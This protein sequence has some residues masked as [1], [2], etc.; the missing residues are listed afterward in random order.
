MKRDIKEPILFKILKILGPIILVTGIVLLIV[1]MV[2]F[3]DGVASLSGF[4]FVALALL[5]IGSAATMFGLIPQMQKMTIKTNKYIHQA[6]KEDL[7]EIA[8]TKAEIA[9]D[10]LSETA[11]AVTRGIKQGLQDEPK[12]A[13]AKSKYCKH[14]GA[15]IDEDSKFCKE[16]GGKL[17]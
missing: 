1:Y 4:G 17:E 10:A 13:K 2:G 3:T 5:F 9:G 15:K 12:K 7:K 8:D 14:C 11:T 6:N 16:C